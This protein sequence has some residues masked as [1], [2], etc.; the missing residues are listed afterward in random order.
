MSLVIGEFELTFGWFLF[1]TW[2]IISI[3]L[4]AVSLDKNSKKDLAEMTEEEKEENLK[5]PWYDREFA[6]YPLIFKILF[7][8]G[9]IVVAVLMVIHMMIG[10]YAG[11]SAVS[12]FFNKE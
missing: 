1:L 7:P 9:I 8:I 5:G 12:S 4:I 6:T 3:I 11:L 2:V 10:C